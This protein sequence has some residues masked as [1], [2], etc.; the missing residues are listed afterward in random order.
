MKQ[1]YLHLLNHTKIHHQSKEKS[2]P[3]LCWQFPA[4]FLLKIIIMKKIIIIK[5]KNH[6]ILC[7]DRAK[8]SSIKSVLGKKY[9]SLF[10]FVSFLACVAITMCRAVLW[11][12][13]IDI[14]VWWARNF[15]ISLFTFC[16]WLYF[17]FY[18]KLK[19]N[20]WN[21]SIKNNPCKFEEILKWV[22]SP[23]LDKLSID[24]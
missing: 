21:V 24:M 8:L 14:K 9:S 16:F 19:K 18:L 15:Y 7:D 10:K 13:N 12:T 2:Q 22:K 23:S 20:I 6:I 17:M 4:D 11:S 5:L 3:D 1:T